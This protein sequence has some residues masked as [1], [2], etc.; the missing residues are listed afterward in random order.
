MQQAIPIVAA[1]APARLPTPV[2]NTLHA[3][4]PVDLKPAGNTV[5][6]TTT[7]QNP[8]ALRQ[9]ISVRTQASG[10]MAPTA[11]QAAQSQSLLTRF[12][13]GIGED[14]ANTGTPAVQ[15]QAPSGGVM[16]AITNIFQT[17]SSAY[18]SQQAAKAEIAKAEQ[19]KAK[20]E[21]EGNR[22]AA[23]QA[24]ARLDAILATAGKAQPWLL[25][26]GIALLG[27]AGFLMLRNKRAGRRLTGRRR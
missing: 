15:S 19:E 2:V 3:R 14:P 16:S 27:V 12:I 10:G 5:A 6:I 4:E 26:G 8:F 22:T 13:P 7:A 21:A 17:G 20:A 1:Q 18:A 24:Q 25:Y 11:P 9:S 23:I